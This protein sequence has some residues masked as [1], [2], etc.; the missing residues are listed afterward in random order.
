MTEGSLLFL[1]LE[2][3][4]FHLSNCCA[5]K[6]GNCIIEP[7]MMRVLSAL[8]TVIYPTAKNTGG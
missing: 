7:H 4:H 1:L 2:N 5:V 3:R 6:H 8:N